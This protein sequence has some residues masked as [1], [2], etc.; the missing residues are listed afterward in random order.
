MHARREAVLV[1]GPEPRARRG[2]VG[3]VELRFELVD[4]D[5]PGRLASC[6]P[7][8]EEL[9]KVDDAAGAGGP[10]TAVDAG[11]EEAPATLPGASDDDES[12]PCL[13]V[14]EGE[15]RGQVF[16]LLLPQKLCE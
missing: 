10:G 3:E 2:E 16:P 13:V 7:D 12:T 4:A 1:Q 8:I 14:I 9:L 11:G 6:A 5:T 15:E